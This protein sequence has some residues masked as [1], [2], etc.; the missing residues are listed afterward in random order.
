MQ[1]TIKPTWQERFYE[2]PFLPLCE[3]CHNAKTG[4]EAAG[5]LLD[6][7]QAN[8]DVLKTLRPTV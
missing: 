7:M 2:G 4:K 1:M 8:W 3:I 6:W 5:K